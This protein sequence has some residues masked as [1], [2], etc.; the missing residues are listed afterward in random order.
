MIS[1]SIRIIRENWHFYLFFVIAMLVVAALADTGIVRSASGTGTMV[2]WLLLALFVHRAALFNLKFGAPNADG[3]ADRSFGGFMFKALALLVLSVIPAMPVLLSASGATGA[4]SQAPDIPGL[5]PFFGATLLSYAVL[6]GLAGSWLPASVYKQNTGLG[7]AFKRGMRNFLPVFI[8]IAAV[9][10]LTI[11]LQFAILMTAG[12]SGIQPSVIRDAMPNVS[13][14]VMTVVET[15]IEAVSITL[16]SVILSHYYL[17][18][19][20]IGGNRPG[21]YDPA[22]NSTPPPSSFGGNV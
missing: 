6:L 20:D 8:R 21:P 14:A 3:T 1:T 16:I 18:A 22:A 9:L 11:V 17:K 19:E 15:S 5:L 13:G 4:D 10:I 2:A 7:A 12:M